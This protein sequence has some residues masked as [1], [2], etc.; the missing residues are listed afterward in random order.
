MAKTK[1]PP[2]PGVFPDHTQHVVQPVG[3]DT[4]PPRRQ[5]S[6]HQRPNAPSHRPHGARSQPVPADATLPAVP[7]PEEAHGFSDPAPAPVETTLTLHVSASLLR[8]L[9]AKAQDEGVSLVVLA[10]E[11]LAEGLVLRAWEILTRQVAMRGGSDMRQ[12]YAT[13]GARGPHA[14]GGRHDRRG[15]RGNRRLPQRSGGNV[16]D[17]QATFLEYVRT[18]ERKRR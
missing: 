7:V 3:S 13:P 15:G 8:Q 12:P 18:Q 6:A 5:R 16:M 10:T 11:L 9:K 4:T 1:P 17:D 14:G 2:T